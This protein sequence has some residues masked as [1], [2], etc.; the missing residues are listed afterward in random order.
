MCS[1]NYKLLNDNIQIEIIKK[2]IFFEY[3]IVRNFVKYNIK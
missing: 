3:A 2:I 1:P